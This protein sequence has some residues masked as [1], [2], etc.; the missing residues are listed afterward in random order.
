MDQENGPLAAIGKE[1][2]QAAQFHCSLHR[3]Q[4]IIETLGG[5]KGLTPLKALWMYN[6]LCG[7]HSVT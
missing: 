6:L 3:R 1:V 5:G 2:K 7:C 4:N